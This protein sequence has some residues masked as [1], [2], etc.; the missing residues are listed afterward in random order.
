MATAQSLQNLNTLSKKIWSEVDAFCGDKMS[1]LDRSSIFAFI[2]QRLVY[3][4]RA[5][6][7]AKP[8][9]TVEPKELFPCE[10]SFKF[11]PESC[12]AT[13]KD[14]HPEKYNECLTA[15]QEAVKK[16]AKVKDE[17]EKETV[18]KKEKKEKDFWGFVKDSTTGKM[19]EILSS[20][21]VT[22]ERISEELG[23]TG[24]RIAVHISNLKKEGWKVLKK[25]G[26]DD[27]LLYKL[28][29][30]RVETE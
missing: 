18:E 9:E 6:T 5:S 11:D 26:N 17:P 7:V 1:D 8:Q 3:T 24:T 19:N 4:K 27:E 22:K 23:I 13:C 14:E 2:R 16:R 30:T 29:K 21:F 10:N 15:F 20:G 25:R 12:L 28:K